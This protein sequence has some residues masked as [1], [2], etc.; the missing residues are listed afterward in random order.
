MAELITKFR[1]FLDSREHPLVFLLIIGLI[2]RCLLAPFITFNIDIAYWA[3]VIDVFQNGFGLYGTA[4]YY[5]TPVWGYFLGATSLIGSLIGLTDV[6]QYVPEL[7]HLV[8]EDFKISAFVTSMQFNTLV[9]LPLILV[10][11]AVGVLLYEFT[12]K[13]TK[14]RNKALLAFSLWF[15]SPLVITESSVHAMFDNISAMM[16]LITIILAYDKKYFFAGLA[17][18]GAVLTKFFPAFFVFFFIAF[19]L[20]REKIDG[21]GVKRLAQAIAGFIIGFFIIYIPN[22]I[23]GRFWDSMYF[24]AYRL[25]ITREMLASISTTM[26][27]GIFAALFIVLALFLFILKRYGP[28][29]KKDILAMD[30]KVRDRKFAKIIFSICGIVIVLVMIYTAINA[31]VTGIM[32]FFTSIGMKAVL[33]VSIFSI[34]VEIYL[35]YRLLFCEDESDRMMIVLL[36][37]TAMAIIL[38]PCAPSYALIMMPFLILYAAIVDRRFI[39]PYLIFS[40]LMTLMEL[41][42]FMTSLTSVSVYTGLMS[43]DTI[44]SIM[45]WLAYPQ[46]LG[47]SG[48]WIITAIFGTAAY[49]SLLYISYKWYSEYI[50]GDF[51]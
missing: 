8:N 27:I 31:D 42:A 5:Y 36:M 17:F 41:S 40:V 33:M 11:V 9:K 16:V 32:E 6:G 22:I 49:L 23:S 3:E 10:D 18:S 43:I 4:G 28:A 47:I 1:E 24:L 12:K 39:R 46:I 34:F 15:F 13:I 14:D 20:K 44:V 29:W 7:M 26:T 38:W 19:V 25:G 35:A 48:N 30:K 45:E 51:K 2:I 50:R 37:L 21:E